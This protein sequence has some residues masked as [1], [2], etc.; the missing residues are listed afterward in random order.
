M[1]QKN[2]NHPPL[3]NIYKLKVLFR[4]LWAVG[5]NA[6]IAAMFLITWFRPNTFGPLTVHHLT[7]VMLMEFIV[8]HAT[9][10]LG[11][12]SARDESVKYRAAMFV[13]LMSFY[14]LFAAGFAAMYGGWWPIWAFWGLIL[15]RFPTVVLRPPDMQ[16]QNVLIVNWA[17]MVMLYLGGAL[18]T[19][20]PDVSPIG[21]TPDVI[22]AQHFDTGGL[23]PEQPYRVM[24]FGTFYFTG[25]GVLGAINEIISIRST[26]NKD[27]RPGDT[28]G[29]LPPR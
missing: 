17:M 11:A 13:G 5:T 19:A 25:L 1:E 8:V 29:W 28:G 26:G 21:I 14:M 23:W 16:G 7:F 15:S 4:I 2:T 24:A 27:K 22:A 9:G 3:R 18:L 20:V 6:W 10:F 12:I